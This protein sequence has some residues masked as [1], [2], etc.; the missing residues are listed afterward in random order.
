[1]AEFKTYAFLLCAIVFCTMTVI[2]I[3]VVAI[4]MKLSARIVECG[5]EDEDIIEE[6]RIKYR[7]KKDREG[8]SY[9]LN[10][11][12]SLIFLLFFVIALTMN[13]STV[14]YSDKLPTLRVVQSGSMSSKYKANT[15]LFENDLNDQFY[16]HDVVLTYK[17]PDEFDLQLYDIVVYDMD[18]Q[19][20]I[21]RIVGIEEPNAQHPDCRHFVLQGDA[22][23]FRDRFPVLYSQMKGIYRGQNIRFIGSFVTFLQSFAGWMCIGL[24]VGACLFAPLLDK[25]LEKK[26]RERLRCLIYPYSEEQ[27]MW[28]YVTYYDGNGGWTQ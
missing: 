28:E 4:I 7:K 21:H 15:Y 8:G 1:M 14:S 16:T 6:F 17:M 12:V 11:I 9:V 27:I 5:G 13:F 20:V 25:S 23:E 18:G 10:V 2:T 22:S 19:L 24:I 26:R 3:V